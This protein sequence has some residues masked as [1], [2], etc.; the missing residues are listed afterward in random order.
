MRLVPA[1][2]KVQQCVQSCCVCSGAA[3]RCTLSARAQPFISC[4]SP[5]LF[6]G[7]FKARSG[8]AAASSLGITSPRSKC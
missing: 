1:D 4:F 7:L 3:R 8:G 6:F 5:V 2:G